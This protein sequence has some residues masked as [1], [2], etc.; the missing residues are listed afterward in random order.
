MS[1]RAHIADIAR[2]NDVTFASGR[3]D[4][5]RHHTVA[6]KQSVSDGS[7]TIRA[8]GSDFRG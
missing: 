2:R 5:N 3:E 8:Y 1:L 7:S 4:L 6:K